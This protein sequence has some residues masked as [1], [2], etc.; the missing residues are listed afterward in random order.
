MIA[1]VIPVNLDLEKAKKAGI[2][3]LL[4]FLHTCELFEA[5]QTVVEEALRLGCASHAFYVEH[6][7]GADKATLVGRDC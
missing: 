1:T 3:A 2:M 4:R 5:N 6:E 7:I